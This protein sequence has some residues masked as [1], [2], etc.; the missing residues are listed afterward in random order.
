MYDEYTMRMV[1]QQGIAERHRAAE[2][3]RLAAACR[4]RNR[5]QA[6][7][8]RATT[9]PPGFHRRWLARLGWLSHF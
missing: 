3:D 7:A 2:A 8:R 5:E 9:A 4:R 1:A 6:A